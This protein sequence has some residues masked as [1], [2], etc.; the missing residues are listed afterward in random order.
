MHGIK[1]ATLPKKNQSALVS[2]IFLLAMITSKNYQ[3]KRFIIYIYILQVYIYVTKKGGFRNTLI[4]T[5]LSQF[6]GNAT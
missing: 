6:R 1:E 5:L 2:N 4:I 3:G